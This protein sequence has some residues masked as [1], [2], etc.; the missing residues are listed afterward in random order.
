MRQL[1]ETVLAASTIIGKNKKRKTKDADVLSHQLH[2]LRAACCHP[3]VGTSGIKKV[4]KTQG[5]NTGPSI[6]CGVLSMSQIL[7]RLIDDAKIKA[8]ESQRVWTLN[9]NALACLFKLKAEGP[10]G[11]GSIIDDQDETDLLKKSCDQYLDAIEIAN[12]NASPTSIVG[13]ATVVGCNGFQSD[14]NIIRDGAAVLEWVVHFQENSCESTYPEVWSRFDF[15]GSTKK[16]N[17]LAVRPMVEPPKNLY[18]S[19]HEI[20]YPRECVLQVSNAALGGMFVDAFSFTLP[21]PTTPSPDWQQVEG[22]LRPH[23]SKNWR[24]LV[25]TFYENAE[26]DRKEDLRKA[27][28]GLEIQLMEPDIVPDSLQRLHILHNSELTL[29][30]LQRKIEECCGVEIQDDRRNRFSKHHIATTIDETKDEKKNLESHYI[31]AARVFQLASQRRLNDATKKRIDLFHELQSFGGKE[32]GTSMHNHSYQ[33]WQDLL[34]YC[35]L[36]SGQIIQSSLIE[37]VEASLF[38]LYNDPSQPYSRRSFPKVNSLDGLNIAL[39]MRLEDNSFFPALGGDARS[40]KVFKCLGEITALSDTPSASE[41]FENSHCHKVR[42]P[43][44]CALSMEV[45]KVY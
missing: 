14:G 13:E 4:Q 10:E 12:K 9:T 6:A 45:P 5:N 33:W 30:A 27:F 34:A 8:E 20:V 15:N 39:S 40:N 1:E 19:S 7:D 29:T 23:K 38:D 17:Y 2:R 16:I 37:L 18:G 21:K 32:Q 42:T 41:I 11:I 28:A 3:Q 31:E 24:L 44:K 26:C 25:K 22:G 36:Q 43:V 35:H